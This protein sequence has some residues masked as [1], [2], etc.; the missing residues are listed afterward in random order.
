MNNRTMDFV[1]MC[2]S[3]I[4]VLVRNI[5]TVITAQTNYIFCKKKKKYL[6]T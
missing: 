3:Y 6:L 4:N 5:V 1:Q 2:E